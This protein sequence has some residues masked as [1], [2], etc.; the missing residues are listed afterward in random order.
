MTDD[1]KM[2]VKCLVDRPADQFKP[3]WKNVCRDCRR[4]ARKAYAEAQ[5]VRMARQRAPAAAWDGRPRSWLA[6][7]PRGV[8]EGVLDVIEQIGRMK[9]D[10]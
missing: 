6:P 3:Y 9:R 8:A 2:C 7:V 4:L 1:A 10:G 5:R